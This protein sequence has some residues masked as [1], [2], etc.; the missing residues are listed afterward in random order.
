MVKDLK[1]E[2]LQQQRTELEL[3]IDKA[4]TE[5]LALIRAKEQELVSDIYHRL[6]QDIY[7]SM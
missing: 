4:H 1:A 6:P 5:E 2:N 3:L 7:H